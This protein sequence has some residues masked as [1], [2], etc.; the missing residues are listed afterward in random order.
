MWVLDL[1]L[2][3]MG[4]LMIALPHLFLHLGSRGGVKTRADMRKLGVALLLLSYAFLGID[5]FFLR[6]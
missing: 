2:M 3:V 4:I 6:W 1:A 5:H